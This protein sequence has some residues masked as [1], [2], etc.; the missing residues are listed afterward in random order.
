MGLQSV[1]TVCTLYCCTVTTMTCPYVGAVMYGLFNPSGMWGIRS[2]GPHATCMYY[3]KRVWGKFRLYSLYCTHSYCTAMQL[4]IFSR[5][6]DKN[7]LHSLLICRFGCSLFVSRVACLCKLFISWPFFVLCNRNYVL[8]VCCVTCWAN[9]VIANRRHV[10]TAITS[11]VRPVW[12][13]Y[14]VV[15]IVHNPVVCPPLCI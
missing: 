13:V 6:C 10:F 12:P 14:F 7:G 1:L 3:R 8:H 5:G 2:Y 9:E 11:I 4:Y 15:D